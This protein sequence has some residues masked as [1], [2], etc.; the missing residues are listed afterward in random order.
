MTSYKDQ[1]Q[2]SPKDETGGIHFCYANDVLY[3]RVENV[4]LLQ[5]NSCYIIKVKKKMKVQ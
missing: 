3:M 4:I 5:N 2:P 1:D